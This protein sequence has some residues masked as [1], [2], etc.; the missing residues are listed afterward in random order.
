MAFKLRL[1]QYVTNVH[2]YSTKEVPFDVQVVPR[3]S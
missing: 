1:K 2:N 3:L